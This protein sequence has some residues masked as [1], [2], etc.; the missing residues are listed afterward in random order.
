MEVAAESE[1]LAQVLEDQDAEAE[2]VVAAKALAMGVPVEARA[3]GV[4]ERV[5]AARAAD[6]VVVE[7]VDRAALEADPEAVG[8]VAEGVLVDL[9]AGVPDQVEEAQAEQV[10][11]LA[12]EV[13]VAEEVPLAEEVQEPSPANG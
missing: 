2:K 8:E 10:E 6:P 12:A 5:S 13:R 3:E 9:E 1:E 4:G 7:L 11:V